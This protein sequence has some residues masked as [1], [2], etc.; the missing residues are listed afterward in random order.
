VP[1]GE[2][3]DAF[4][5]AMNDDLGVPR[6]LA[7][8]HEKVRAGN[9]ALARSDDDAA[10]ELASSVR[11]MVA[12]LGLDPWAAPWVERKVD[13]RLVEATGRLLDGL[14]AERAQARADRDFARADEI[15][16][17]V[18]AA[19]FAIEDTKDGPVWSVAGT[20]DRL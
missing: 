2:V 3:P 11:A 16:T 7:V 13:R 20:P 1:I 18:A 17:Q 4:R 9:A 19:G 5:Q 8:V 6:A 15:R 12:V 14:L 10:Q